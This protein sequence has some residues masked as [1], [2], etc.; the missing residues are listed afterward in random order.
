MH[1]DREHCIWPD[2]V[3]EMKLKETID[4]KVLTT[5]EMRI[6]DEELRMY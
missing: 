4:N 5:N 2:A 1:L 3:L 6:R